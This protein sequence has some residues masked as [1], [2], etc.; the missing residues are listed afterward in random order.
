MMTP[1]RRWTGR[2]TTALRT[3]L[4]LSLRDFA[5]HLGV[6]ARTVSKWEAGGRSVC[7]R[8]EMQA[9]L[10]TALHRG[11]ADVEARFL[12]LLQG[13]GGCRRDVSTEVS[14]RDDGSLDG[15]SVDDASF[16]ARSEWDAMSPLTRRLLMAHGVAAAA[17]PGNAVVGLDNLARTAATLS[18]HVASAAAHPSWDSTVPV[19]S[20]AAPIYEAVVDPTDAMARARLA[21]GKDGRAEA[22]A[23]AEVRSHRLTRVL[24]SDLMSRERRSSGLRA[25]ARRCD[26]SL[27]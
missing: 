20:W 8:P 1:V 16:G 19:A 7:P 10:D 21:S 17:W 26:P 14:T 24:L 23:P 22:I 3:A 13:Q 2:E 12:L 11:G 27:V 25:L 15:L 18:G 6:G 4:R 9:A 5:E